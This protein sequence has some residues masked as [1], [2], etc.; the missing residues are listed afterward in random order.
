[1]LN[2]NRKKQI[3]PKISKYIKEQTNKSIEKYLIKQSILE[4]NNIKA[5]HLFYKNTI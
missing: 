1:M 2:F 5:Y 3:C 4:V